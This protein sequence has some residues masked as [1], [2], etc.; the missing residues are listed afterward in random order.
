MKR[1]LLKM[2]R[3]VPDKVFIRFSYLLNHGRLPDLG[4]PRTF[5]EKLQWYKLHYR[6]PVMAR[7]ADK[8]AVRGYLAD[9]GYAGLL[10]EL[11][12][13]FDKVEEIDFASLPER[14]VLKAT[15][16]WQMDLICKNKRDLD[17]GKCRRLMAGWLK[18]NHFDVGREWAYK[19]I[20]PRIICEKYLE[21]E[22]I[23]ELLDYKFYCFQGKAEAMFV[24]TGR[25]SSRG[26]RYRC[27]DM[28][29]RE[30]KVIKGKPASEIHVEKP[31]NF[32]AMKTIAED[33]ARG[34]PF[35]RVDFYEVGGRVIFGELTFYPDC[36]L[37]AF[38]PDRYN[39]FWGDL[40][41]LPSQPLPETAAN[42]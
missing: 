23:G 13:V 21:N 40:F 38:T 10:N 34:F 4:H 26:V 35:L 28:N 7:M 36:G 9:R 33:L 8:Y 14:F 25:Q 6:R 20:P 42:L 16:G 32:E 39:Y 15:H 29:W 11:Y 5:N 27:Y 37:H 19:H 17:W 30:I 1:Y 3:V 31:R 41:V 2:L 24:C 18:T 22:T 12:G